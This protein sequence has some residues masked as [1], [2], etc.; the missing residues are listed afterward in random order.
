[1]I[2][3]DPTPRAEKPERVDAR[4]GD[5]HG[6]LDGRDCQPAFRTC[7]QQTTMPR[8]KSGNGASPQAALSRARGHGR[9]RATPRG[10]DTPERS[11]RRPRPW[12]PGG[13]AVTGEHRGPRKTPRRQVVR[14]PHSTRPGRVAATRQLPDW[15]RPLPRAKSHLP[16]ELATLSS[17]RALRLRFRRRLPPVLLAASRSFQG[18]L[19]SNRPPRSRSTG[20]AA[21]TSSCQLYSFWFAA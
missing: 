2:Y 9:E 6:L 17:G 20:F 5:H 18:C 1:M 21:S 16:P 7:L 11:E 12:A 3:R 10:V 19:F 14:A 13:R 4:C 8:V 15:L